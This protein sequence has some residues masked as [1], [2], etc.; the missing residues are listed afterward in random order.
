MRLKFKILFWAGVFS[1]F[2]VFLISAW[3]LLR[4]REGTALRKEAYVLQAKLYDVLE[5]L[6]T[7]DNTF[8]ISKLDQSEAGYREFLEIIEEAKEEINV[9]ASTKGQS[10][11]VNAEILQLKN[12]IDQKIEV[13]N[14]YYVNHG[15]FFQP[16]VKSVVEIKNDLL[17]TEAVRERIDII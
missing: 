17:L 4:L 12:L 7:A 16:Q 3:S 14:N 5:S 15:S 1:L 11:N 6:E 2:A 10:R 8:L 13:T 9:L